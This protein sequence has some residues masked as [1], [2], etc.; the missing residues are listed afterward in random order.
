[1][2]PLA[3]IAQG[4]SLISSLIGKSG[5]SSTQLQMEI[6]NQL[7]EVNSNLVKQ[8]MILANISKKIE[9]IPE[10][11][12]LFDAKLNT[13][14]V[15]TQIRKTFLALQP[16]GIQ[17][18]DPNQ[19]YQDL[20]SAYKEVKNG[21]ANISSVLVHTKD[22]E[23]SLVEL[24]YP[25]ISIMQN[26]RLLA[27]IMCFPAWLVQYMNEDDI[28]LQREFVPQPH[29]SPETYQAI[30]T[31]IRDLYT[32]IIS[33][34]GPEYLDGLSKSI[35]S[36][37]DPGSTVPGKLVFLGQGYRQ[38]RFITKIHTAG[39][40][41]SIPQGFPGPFSFLKTWATNSTTFSLEIDCPSGFGPVSETETKS[42]FAFGI[43]FS[44][45]KARKE[46]R[47]KFAN[48][49]I[50]FKAITG[51]HMKA[52]KISNSQVNAFER[53][54]TDYISNDPN[55]FYTSI[56]NRFT[57]FQNK[58][59]FHSSLAYLYFVEEKLHRLEKQ[60]I[61]SFKETSGM[62]ANHLAARENLAIYLYMFGILHFLEGSAQELTEEIGAWS[63]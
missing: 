15:E 3:L 9:N 26:Y 62:N 18:T 24:S 47:E 6:I 42:P 12:A 11:Q 7:G 33:Q 51:N 60:D 38:D 56:L 31:Q 39:I 2:I 49:P 57:Q 14:I 50:K 27:G 8:N 46:W 53:M 22:I 28:G 10:Q 30:V 45:D 5:P 25:L 35:V 4:V 32:G 41:G 55:S 44:G 20:I 16:E 21:F 48:S 36:F 63:Q 29:I 54:K 52:Q 17:V 23:H 13:T 19:H 61:E 58:K 59:V 34:H 40:F 1:M 43:T 37:A